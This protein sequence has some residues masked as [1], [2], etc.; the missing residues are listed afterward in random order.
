MVLCGCRCGI[1]SFAIEILEVLEPRAEATPAGLAE[2][3][4]V[5]EALWREKL[6]PVLLY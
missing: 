1:N 4:A 2:D 5:L 3:L 6:G